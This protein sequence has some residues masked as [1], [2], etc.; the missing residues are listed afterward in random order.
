MSFTSNVFQVDTRNI[1][2]DTE[3]VVEGGRNLFTL[4]QKGFKGIKQI[5]V[6]G[7]G[8]QGPAQAQNLRDSLEG[9]DIIVVVGLREGSS[10]MPAAREA[11]FNENDRTLGEMFEVIHNSDLVLFL[12][13][14]A[15]QTQLFPEVFKALKEGATLGFSH[16]FLLGHMKNVG[17]NFPKEH[18]IVMVAPKGM[19]AS[20]R[21]LYQQGKD[22]NGAGINSSFAVQQ[23]VDG[24]ATN[25]A[26]AW[27]IGIGS[28]YVFET[29][30]EMEYRSDIF[31]ERGVLLG[32]VWG[33]V[34]ALYLR[35]K[36]QGKSNEEAFALAVESLTGPIS[37]TMSHEG[38]LSVYNGLNEAEKQEFQ[39][40]Y[41]AAY[42][43]FKSVLQ[44][45]YDE[46]LSGNEINSVIMAGKRLESNPMGKIDG[47]EMW[48]VG[49][50][51]R[52]DRKNTN[53]P[54]EASTAGFYI[55]MMMAQVDV[56]RENDH[57]WSEI[58]N[59]SI[60][61][62]TDSLNPFMH[63]K[64]V[65]AMVDGCSTTARLGARKWG[66]Q[67][68]ASLKMGAFVQIDNDSVDLGVFASFVDHPIHEVW[69][70]C[71]EMRPTV[72]IAI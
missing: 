9:T 55:A 33:M 72:D 32:G 23:D 71:A 68:E 2:G 11:G 43:G 46:V 69:K 60:I 37:S 53:T 1:G 34:E 8:S 42:P 50:S 30:M 64:G 19:G 10:S 24:R 14:D 59:E 56:L 41:C 15:S 25:I 17:A 52:S 63:K 20:V 6:I 38:L 39:T 57:S 31:G 67:F 36:S 45:I 16:G 4:L 13:S 51:V 28:P 5:G 7:W 27:A 44:E 22:V 54:V 3:Q 47:T 49:I 21:L 18:N 65:S 58:A 62:A 12:T 66:P 48:K 26:L 35:F 40:A 61:E 70:T 29:T